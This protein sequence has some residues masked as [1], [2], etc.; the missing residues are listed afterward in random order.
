MILDEATSALDSHS[1]LMIQRSIDYLSTNTTIVV[2]AHRLATIKKS[3]YIYQLESGRVIEEGTF[4]QLMQI[5]NGA[6]KTSATLQG[7]TA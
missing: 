5:E 7:I 4:N 6:F 3:D 2:I 1:E